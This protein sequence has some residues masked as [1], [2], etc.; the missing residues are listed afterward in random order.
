MPHLENPVLLGSYY[1]FTYL[2]FKL[3]IFSLYF[4]TFAIF[5]QFYLTIYIFILRLLLLFYV[6]LRISDF[7][8]FIEAQI[9]SD[10]QVPPIPPNLKLPILQIATQLNFLL[11]IFVL[12]YEYI[13]FSILLQMQYFSKSIGIISV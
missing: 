7:K 3:L 5:N 1:S 11:D 10:K 12:M 9:P 13:G 6:V 8:A 4:Y 2:L